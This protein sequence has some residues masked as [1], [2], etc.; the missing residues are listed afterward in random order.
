MASQS[1]YR[2]DN[3]WG[4]SGDDEETT[5]LEPTTTPEQTTRQQDKAR[6]IA[7]LLLKGVSPAL[8]AVTCEDPER[9]PVELS[10]PTHYLPGGVRAIRANETDGY[11]SGGEST[12]VVL[13]GT[14]TE[15]FLDLVEI[16]LDHCV[17]EGLIG[18]ELRTELYRDAQ[19]MKTGTDK[20]DQR[21][22]ALIVR[23]ALAATRSGPG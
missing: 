1:P 15:S 13:D 6:H 5:H 14:P 18:R 10:E 12:A 19:S 9:T 20:R 17:R 4:E 8:C 11:L 7:H 3:W 2:R 23:D 21:I 16:W 22:L